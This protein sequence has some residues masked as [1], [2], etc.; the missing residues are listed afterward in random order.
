MTIR[1]MGA[2]NCYKRTKQLLDYSSSLSEL[3]MKRKYFFL[4]YLFQSIWIINQDKLVP[5]VDI[6]QLSIQFKFTQ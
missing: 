3:R 2:E 1:F 6:G 4:Y 5:K